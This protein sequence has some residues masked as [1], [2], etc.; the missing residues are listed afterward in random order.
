MRHREIE[1]SAVFPQDTARQG[2]TRF[3]SLLDRFFGPPDRDRFAEQVIQALRA[4]GDTRTIEYDADNFRLHFSGAESGSA[5]SSLTNLY[6]EHCSVP[7]RR[8]QQHLKHIVRGL[9][10]YL[11]E[12]PRDFDAARPDLRPVVRTRCY[13]DLM[14][15]HA[16]IERQDPPGIPHASIGSHLVAMLVYDLPESMQSI[17]Q[18]TLDGWGI[19]FF[20]AM[21]IAQH[22][23]REV[24]FAFASIGDALYAS[25][26]G[27][28]YD[29]SRLLLPEL[30]ERIDTQGPPLVI[31]ANRDT[32]LITGRDDADGVA[33]LAEL[34]EKALDDP[35]PMSG[36]PVV[37][38]E[39]DWAT[40]LPESDH[41][42]YAAFR[43]L[44]VKTLAGE[45]ADQQPLLQELFE[46]RGDDV[47]VASYSAAEQEGGS[48]FSYCVWSEGVDSVLPRTDT[49]MLYR[50]EKDEHIAVSWSKAAPIVGDLLRPV[51]A[52]PERFRARE[53]PSEAQ[54]SELR[55]VAESDPGAE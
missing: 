43:L 7:Y 17:S 2:K 19:S 16:G 31:V 11:K 27:D 53:F 33:M 41:P 45:Y 36:I 9:L 12:V 15:L 24:E 37:R 49:L 13:L 4:A 14:R 39:D 51:E 52:Y 28:N 30:F 55:N 47:Y 3:M 20:E 42:Q 46:K 35:R 5:T 18:E 25:M 8:R 22:N 50:P 23:L 6:M 10:T 29:A 48:L 32:L 21:E 40:W 44:E 54:L 26:S 34:A 38:E 1:E